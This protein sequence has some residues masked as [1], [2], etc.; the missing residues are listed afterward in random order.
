VALFIYLKGGTNPLT[1]DVMT[2][3]YNPELTTPL[4][5]VRFEIQD[6]EEDV[7]DFSNEEINATYVSS[8][9][10]LYKTSRKLLH[11]LWMR[12]ARSPTKV[13]VDGVRMDNP[14]RG[15]VFKALYDSLED[16]EKEE[17]RRLGK[18]SPIKATG[19]NRSKFNANREDTTLVSPRFTQ[20]Q[21]D[22]NPDY[23]ELSPLDKYKY[24]KGD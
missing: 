4:D 10:K 7:A 22:W 8:G 17:T 23:P 3:S 21:V 13:E 9:N 18:G 5:Q 16:L 2:F 12:Y 6:T 20:Q 1:G 24:Y 11:K 19:I 15:E 14:K